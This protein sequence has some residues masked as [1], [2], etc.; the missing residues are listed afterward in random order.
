VEE[1]EGNPGFYAATFHLKPHYQL[2]GVSVS[3]RLV[4]KLPSQKK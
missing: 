3:M 2:E 1:I 4:S